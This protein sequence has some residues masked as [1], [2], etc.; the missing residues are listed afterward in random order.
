MPNIAPARALEPAWL[1]ETYGSGIINHFETPPQFPSVTTAALQ[2]GRHGTTKE[3][4]KRGFFSH[5]HLQRL[6]NRLEST[7]LCPITSYFGQQ[8]P[9]RCC[10]DRDLKSGRLENDLRFRQEV[11]AGKENQGKGRILSA[12]R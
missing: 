9:I 10:G 8:Y 7:A 5:N 6:P 1:P 11:G 2:P 12:H 4:T 3:L